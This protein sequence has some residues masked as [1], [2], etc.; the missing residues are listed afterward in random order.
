VTAAALT[1]LF[2]GV[3]PEVHGIDSEDFRLPRAPQRLQPLTRVLAEAGIP[4][5]TFIRRMPWLYRGL[6]RQ[7]A[8]YAGVKDA[9]FVGD[10]AAELLFAARAAIEEQRNGFI[11][12]HWPDADT[13]GHEHAWMSDEYGRAARR[14]DTALGFLATQLDIVNDPTTLLI[15]CADH[16]GGGAT[17]KHHNSAHPDDRTIPVLL[18]GGAVM[19][20]R[21]RDDVQWL[22]IP[23]TVL[24]ALGVARP[25]AYEGRPLS[26]AFAAATL[27]A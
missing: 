19:P 24:W 5:A 26:E 17:P 10:S 7:M 3:S 20:G 2:T 8:H 4:C 27:V 18:A 13:A 22:D 6:A 21:L 23:A 11:F 15:A 25:A 12:L 1:S 14:L 9:H 16:G